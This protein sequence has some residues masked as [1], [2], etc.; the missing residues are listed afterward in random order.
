MRGSPLLRAFLAFLILLGLGFPLH[1]LL[2]SHGV[3]NTAENVLEPEK[4]PTEAKV[5]LQVSFT[6]P[7]TEFRVQSLGREVWKETNPGEQ[8]QHELPLAFP[9]EGI[10]LLVDAAWPAGTRGAAQVRLTDP[11]GIEHVKHLFGE[12]AVSEVLAFP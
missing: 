9:K 1:R 2:H 12:G 5:Q 10:E 4:P 7:P 11:E 8:L 3:A 6:T